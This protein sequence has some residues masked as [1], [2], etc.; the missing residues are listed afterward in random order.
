MRLNI[1]QPASGCPIF[2]KRKKGGGT[3]EALALTQSNELFCD[4]DSFHPEMDVAVIVVSTRFSEGERVGPTVLRD[5]GVKRRQVRVRCCIGRYSVQDAAIILPDNGRAIY[6]CV[7]RGRTE[8]TIGI[9]GCSPTCV[10]VFD[11]YVRGGR[12]WR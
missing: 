8:E 10:V 1:P 5:I 2:P 12:G 9:G 4:Y 11:E 6:D 3:V 7:V